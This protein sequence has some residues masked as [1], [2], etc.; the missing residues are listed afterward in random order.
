M[1]VYCPRDQHDRYA[2]RRTG[3]LACNTKDCQCADCHMHL[4]PKELKEWL[5][6]K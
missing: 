5:G 6:D 1:N 2:D 4:S 3:K